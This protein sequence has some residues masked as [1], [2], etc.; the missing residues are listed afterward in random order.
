MSSRW[1]VAPVYRAACFLVG[2]ILVLITLGGQVTSKVAGMAVPDWPATFGHNMFLF[3]WSRMTASTMVFLEHSHRLVASGV[4]L[5][6]LAVATMVWI[7]RPDKLA[8]R[9]AVAAVVLVVTQGVLGGQRVI[10]VSWVL[11][12]M[13]GCLAQFFLLVAG[14]LAL[15]LSNFWKNPGRSDDDS[16]SRARMVWGLTLLA[17]LQTVLGALMRHEGPGFLA[18][19]DF[20]K[21]YG[22]WWPAFWDAA[23]LQ[24]INTLRAVDLQ[25]PATSSSL[26]LAQFL[27]RTLGVILAISMVVGSF[28][29]MRS[30]SAPDWWRKGIIGWSFLALLQMGLGVSVIW[31]GRLPELATLHVL[32]GASLLL[33]GWLLGLASWRSA[34]PPTVRSF[35]QPTLGRKAEVS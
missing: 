24:K 22:Q 13:H 34:Y 2:S 9:L 35:Q 17:F 16:L 19:P 23:V 3:P 30:V 6:T 11:G 32:F 33:T 7:A 12:L 5:I 31:T 8:R 29:S 26:I 28:W 27:H 21:I 25:W 15:V 1:K 18:I 20:P 14:S 10:Q 4:G